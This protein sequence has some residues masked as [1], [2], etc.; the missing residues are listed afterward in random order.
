MAEFVYKSTIFGPQIFEVPDEGGVVKLRGL[1]LSTNGGYYK[2][3]HS[4]APLRAHPATLEA[5]ARR[6]WR[7]RCSHLS[8]MGEKANGI[9][10]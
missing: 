10:P 4:T 2:L 8:A 9:E 7:K 6:W 3:G 5:V 1:E